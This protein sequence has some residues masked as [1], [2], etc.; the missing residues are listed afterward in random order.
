MAW[1]TRPWEVCTPSTPDL[2]CVF[3]LPMTPSPAFLCVVC[4][5][6]GMPPYYPPPNRPGF[7]PPPPPPP[8]SALSR[9]DN[10]YPIF[11][12]K[13]GS[14]VE[15]TFIE[16]LL[17]V[18]GAACTAAAAAAAAMHVL[19]LANAHCDMSLLPSLLLPSSFPPPSLLLPSSFPPPSLLLPSSLLP[20]CSLSIVAAVRLFE[21]ME[22]HDGPGNRQG[23]RLWVLRIP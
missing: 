23:P 7:A 8:P 13:I 5:A 19:T 10:P 18:C 17:E 15:Y 12:G 20:V 2:C 16:E 4:V 1:V 21:Q 3:T 11:V 6:A 22:R 9:K 14:D